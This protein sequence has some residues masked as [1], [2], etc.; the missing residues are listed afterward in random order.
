MSR[1]IRIRE[2]IVQDIAVPVQRLG[3]ARLG[4]DGVGLEAHSGLRPA[5]C[6]AK[7]SDDRI[8]PPCAVIVQSCAAG[9]DAL[10]GVAIGGH[11][12][13]V[14]RTGLPTGVVAR[15]ADGDEM[16]VVKVLGSKAARPLSPHSA[17]STGS[18]TGLQPVFRGIR[19]E[20][21]FQAVRRRRLRLKPQSDISG[22]T[23]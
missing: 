8:I 5:G 1:G 22:K 4:D 21:Q 16:V 3:I 9:L 18:A 11:P 19:L 17:V 14:L 20:F 2:R 7:P 6:Y 12:S 13:T 10:A 15:A 23:C